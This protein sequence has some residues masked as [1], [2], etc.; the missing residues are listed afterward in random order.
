[1][2]TAQGEAVSFNEGVL[3]NSVTRS[4][5]SARTAM[6]DTA[7]AVHHAVNKPGAHSGSEPI[8]GHQ[9]SPEGQLDHRDRRCEQHRRDGSRFPFEHLPGT[10]HFW[11]N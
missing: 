3:V 7:I 5:S 6:M 11:T 8:D 1:M 10:I 4:S 9:Q 2:A